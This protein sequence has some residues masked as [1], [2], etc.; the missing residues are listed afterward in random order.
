MGYEDKFTAI[1]TFTKLI[2]R[3]IVSLGINK[4]ESPTK[5]DEE[6]IINIKAYISII[7]CFLDIPSTEAL[8][9][10]LMQNRPFYG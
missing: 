5:N 2:L 3:Q 4:L 9:Y 1:S 10:E 8:P 6:D 7:I